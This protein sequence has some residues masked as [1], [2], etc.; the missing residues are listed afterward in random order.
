[1][2][3]KAVHEFPDLKGRLGSMRD[4]ADLLLEGLQREIRLRARARDTSIVGKKENAL[5]LSLDAK[6]CGPQSAIHS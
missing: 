1:M 5:G 4:E 6:G 2:Q 3:L